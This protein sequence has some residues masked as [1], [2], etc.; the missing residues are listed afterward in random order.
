MANQNQEP[1]VH[2]DARTA[3]DM[4]R[5][6]MDPHQ[7]EQATRIPPLQPLHSLPAP[8]VSPPHASPPPLRLFQ[9]RRPHQLPPLR[10]PSRHRLPPPV[11]DAART[12]VLSAAGASLA[13]LAARLH[14][15][16][17]H[18]WLRR[19]PWPPHARRHSVP[20]RGVT[21]V[22]AAHP[23]PFRSV[24]L[25]CGYMDAH[26]R[27]LACWVQTLA[28]RASPTSSSST[29]RGRSTCPFRPALLGVSTLTRLYLGIW[30]FLT[31]PPPA[32]R[33]RPNRRFH[34]SASSSSAPSSSRTATWIFLLAVSPILEVLGIQG[35]RYGVRLRLSG[36]QNPVR[37]DM[38]LLLGEHRRGGH[39]KPRTAHHTGSMTR[40]G[41]FIR[42]KIGNAPNL[43]LLDT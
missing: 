9:W 41:S 5:R 13:L 37:A 12:A 43:R 36:R 2:I 30:K 20:R 16:P 32:R 26:Q 21:R 18:P 24:H 28:I 14:R 31:R 25:V 10:A 33:R 38:P 7:M 35:S 1:F 29:A 17:P 4:R 23:G 11:K 8:P 39:P 6:G 34:T 19:G 40:E 42:I 15:R 27:Q 22:L 3:A